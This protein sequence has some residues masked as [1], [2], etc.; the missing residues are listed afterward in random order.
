VTGA[1]QLFCLPGLYSTDFIRTRG[2]AEGL[3]VRPKGLTFNRPCGT[4]RVPEG[5]GERNYIMSTSYLNKF[6]KDQNKPSCVLVRA[7]FNL[8]G[9]WE[10][11]A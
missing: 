7:Y 3:M 1:A 9:A 4:T 8:Q 5:W 11:V 6:R 2:C 10:H